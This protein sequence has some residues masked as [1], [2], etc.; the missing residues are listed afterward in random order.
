VIFCACWQEWRKGGD[1]IAERKGEKVYIQA[2]LRITE[3]K[4]MEREIGNLLAINDNYP[5]YVVTLDEYSGKT[6]E[7][8]K[9][10]P[11]RKFLSEFQ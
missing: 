7:G 6:F 5:K 10:L 9:H 2:A 3:K 8:I 1:F 4:T 11:L